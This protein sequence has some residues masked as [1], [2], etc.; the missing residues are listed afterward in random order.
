MVNKGFVLFW[1]IQT[2]LQFTFLTSS[3]ARIPHILHFFMASALINASD[4][5]DY[6]TS[7]HII[8]MVLLDTIFP[9]T[10]GPTYT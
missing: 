1:T 7:G 2:P 6:V 8:Y 4:W 3:G 10:L 9:S 5:P